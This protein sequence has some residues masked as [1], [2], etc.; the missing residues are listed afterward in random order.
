MSSLTCSSMLKFF[1][2]APFLPVKGF[3]NV[4][5]F[6][7]Y[8]VVK[9]R[10]QNPMFKFWR[11]LIGERKLTNLRGELLFTCTNILHNFHLNL[12]ISFPVFIQPE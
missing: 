10:D 4:L 11:H 5:N 8:N 7:T 6:V 3:E 9:T 12:A 2:F 1:C